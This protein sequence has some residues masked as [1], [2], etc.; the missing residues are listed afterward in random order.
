MLSNV[1]S[2]GESPTTTAAAVAPRAPASSCVSRRWP[3]N[4]V[5]AS[6]DA[7]TY[8]GAS[9]KC[10]AVHTADADSADWKRDAGI[11]APILPD[12]RA[13]VARLTAEVLVTIR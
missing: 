10:R 2:S 7:R 11:G 12:Q 1:T 3:A 4:S 5:F 13:S 9:G 6:S 8:S